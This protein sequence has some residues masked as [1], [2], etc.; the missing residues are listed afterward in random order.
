MASD[1]ICQAKV[2]YKKIP[3]LL[4]L[5]STHLQW[6]QDGKKGPVLKIPYIQATSLF[7][8]KDGAAQVRLK[9]VVAG[10]EQGHNFTFLAPNITALEEREV[11]KRELSTIISRNRSGLE[12]TPGHLGPP[13]PFPSTP[14]ALPR[15]PQASP[16]STPGPRTPVPIGSPGNPEE[17]HLRK[18]ILL[19]HPEL[20]TLHSD[21]VFGGQITEAEFWEGREHL[22]LAEASIERQTRGKPGR[23]V[24][25]RP[26][27][28][29]GERKITVTPQMVHDIFEEHPVVAKA[30]SENVPNQLTE[31][32]F[33]KR[34][35]QSKL[36]DSHRASIRSSATQNFVR[37]DPIFDKYLEKEDDGLEPRHR[38]NVRV[39]LLVD[40][41]ATQ[42]DHPETGNEKDATMQSGKQRGTIPLI[43][44][45]NRHSERLLNSALGD[46]P[47]AKRR[48]L[49]DTTS[50]PSYDAIDIED[51]HD[52]DAPSIIA[53]EMKDRQRYFEG[54]VLE[55]LNGVKDQTL[56]LGQVISVTKGTLQ[57]WKRSL[58]SIKLDPK[59]A[60]P[61]VASMT[62]QV[63][64]RQEMKKKTNDI[65]EP[66]L[67]QMATCQTAGN[68][69]IRQFWSAVY[70][71]SYETPNQMAASSIYRQAK[72]DRMAEYIAR[73]P[74][75]VE[76]LVQEARQSGTDPERVQAA[77]RPL[78]DAVERAS[79]F[80]R[81]RRSMLSH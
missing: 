66:L 36:F 69:F 73:T 10:D 40:L 77:L 15:G 18:N 24:D 75:K 27:D 8:S 25:P 16:G 31:G 72:L 30:Y 37:E 41:E 43:R 19:K 5:T 17:F 52:P 68:E 51:L 20:A 32:E 1:I 53:L 64:Q 54:T 62:Q 7:C 48:R 4:E 34:Y 28:T 76:A 67:K 11:F 29:N 14:N 44:R 45:F 35:F 2:S 63:N 56:D 74:A 70:P 60:I 80:Y 12:T 55:P 22:I 79:G 13:S 58:A 26:T 47:P 50:A 23:M 42:E 57:N 78:L 38:K 59:S 46:I 39:D 3:G 21:L 33:W 81:A 65:P 49:D 9:L 71:S 61:A 6:S